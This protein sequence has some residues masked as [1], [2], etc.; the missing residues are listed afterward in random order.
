MSNLSVRLK[1]AQP[2]TRTLLP[3]DAPRSTS[4]WYSRRRYPERE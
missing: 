2:A 1:A 4:A 3:Q